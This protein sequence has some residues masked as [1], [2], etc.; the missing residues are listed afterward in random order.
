MTA[1]R[2]FRY[3]AEMTSDG[4]I[5]ELCVL[6]EKHAKAMAGKIDKLQASYWEVE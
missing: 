2:C 4:R 6:G 3:I 1:C 5:K